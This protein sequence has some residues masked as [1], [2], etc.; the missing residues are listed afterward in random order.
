MDGQ[1][2]VTMDERPSV[3]RWVGAVAW[4]LKAEVGRKH[5]RKKENGGSSSPFQEASPET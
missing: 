5:I 1:E 3:P 2:A 4:V